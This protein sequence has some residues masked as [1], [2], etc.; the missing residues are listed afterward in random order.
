MNTKSKLKKNMAKLK[1]QK[2]EAPFVMA[3]SSDMSLKSKDQVFRERIQ[4]M[5]PISQDIDVQKLRQELSK[6]EYMALI[7][8]ILDFNTTQKIS[9]DEFREIFNFDTTNVNLNQ[10][11]DQLNT[12]RQISKY[13]PNRRILIAAFPKSASSYLSTQ[14]SLGLNLPFRHLT[15]SSAYMSQLALNGR[16]QEL[17]ELALCRRALDDV[18][19]VAQHHMKA[20]PYL[21]SILNQYQVKVILTIRNIFDALISFDDMMMKGGW[22]QPF[23]QGASKIPLNYSEMKKDKRLILLANSTGIWYLDFYLSWLRL[24]QAGSNHLIISYEKHISKNTGDKELLFN[25]LVKYLNLNPSEST[26]LRKKLLSDKFSIEKS[27]FNKGVAGRGH[28]LPS[29]AKEHLI[30]HAMF[31]ETELTKPHLQILFGEG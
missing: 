7:K 18:G 6:D 29:A 10:L 22:Q 24:Q 2:A 14:L 9:L 15:T 28:E 1:K 27:R 5:S 20:T 3:K 13:I 21:L 19:F 16:E 4:S 23:M 25:D 17:C 12:I 11:Q 8:S 31:F 30:N 26:G